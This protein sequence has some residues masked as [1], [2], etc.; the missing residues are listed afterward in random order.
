MLP[1]VT[2]PTL[3]IGARQDAIMPTVGTPVLARLI[4]NAHLTWLEECGHL[5]MSEQPVAY[6]QLLC[7]FLEDLA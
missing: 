2:T 4:P 5:P 6:N 7:D 3:I 1:Q